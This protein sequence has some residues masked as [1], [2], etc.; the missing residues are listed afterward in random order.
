MRSHSAEEDGLA[1]YKTKKYMRWCGIRWGVRDAAGAWLAYCVARDY[2]ERIFLEPEG[3]LLVEGC[4][5]WACLD[6]TIVEKFITLEEKKHVSA[7]EA[8]PGA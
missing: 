4:N 5:P 6:D 7:P 8:V 1:F 3:H 2:A